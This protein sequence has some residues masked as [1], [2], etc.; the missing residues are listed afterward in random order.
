MVM[1]DIYRPQVPGFV[2]KEVQ[3]VEKMQDCDKND[4]WRHPMVDL[5]L[6]CD[7]RYVSTCENQLLLERHERLI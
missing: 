3:D 5:V 7:V 4:C 1:R 6:V 2:E